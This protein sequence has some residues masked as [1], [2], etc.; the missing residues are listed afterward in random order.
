MN[1]RYESRAEQADDESRIGDELLVA[2]E[3]EERIAACDER[4]DELTKEWMNGDISYSD[5]E[6][7]ADWVNHHRDSALKDHK[8]A[9]EKINSHEKPL[10]IRQKLGRFVSKYL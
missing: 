9:I 8:I 2:M 4:L 7:H 1:E 6:L 5:Y 10:S 3:R